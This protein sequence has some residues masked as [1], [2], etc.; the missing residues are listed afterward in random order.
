[1]LA[2]LLLIG[3]VKPAYTAETPENILQNGDFDL[4]LEHWHHWT[5]ES[6]AVLTQTDGRKAEPIKGK[7]AAYIRINKPGDAPWHIQFYQQPFT[8]FKGTTYT[9]SLWA[10]SEKL[11]T[12]TMRILHQGAPW[13]IYATQQII[14]SETWNEFFL[15]FEMPMMILIPAP[16]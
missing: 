12:A 14:L 2:T 6:A 15:T 7:N 13:T 8:L 11:R 1:M 10:K 16:V 3:F 5:H 9:Y 4:N